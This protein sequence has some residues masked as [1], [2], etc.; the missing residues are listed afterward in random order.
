MLSKSLVPALRHVMIRAAF[1]II[2][3]RGDAL[4]T[5]PE[6]IIAIVGIVLKNYRPFDVGCSM[7]STSVKDSVVASLSINNDIEGALK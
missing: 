4:M 5:M 1:H 3:S 2:G 7:L 6:T